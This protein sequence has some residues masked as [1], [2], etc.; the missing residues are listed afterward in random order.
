MKK[1]TPQRLCRDC[2]HHIPYS[3]N[4]SIL[5]CAHPKVNARDPL[6]LTAA[7]PGGIP[8]LDERRKTWTLFGRV[9]CGMRGALWQ[10]KDRRL[11]PPP[12]RR[13]WHP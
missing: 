3:G 5:L 4:E 6:V 1:E 12:C 11:L 7:K 10:P 13:D 2:R 9:K 8:A